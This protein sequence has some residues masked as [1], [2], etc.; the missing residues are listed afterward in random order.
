MPSSPAYLQQLRRERREK[1][2]EDNGPCLHCGTWDDLTVDHID[3]SSKDPKLK[4]NAG[5]LWS[6][7]EDKRKTELA[8]CQVLCK[9]CHDRK[10]MLERGGPAKHGTRSMYAGKQKCR[11]DECKAAQSRYMKEYGK[12]HY[13]DYDRNKRKRLS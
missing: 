1:W 11:C 10:T 13:R 2:I 8:K 4:G 9:S 12:S 5:L 7:R 6:W 3:P